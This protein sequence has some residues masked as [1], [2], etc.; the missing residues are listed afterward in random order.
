M[1]S[2]RGMRGKALRGI[3]KRWQS[4]IAPL[5]YIEGGGTIMSISTRISTSFFTALPGALFFALESV[6]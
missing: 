1:A 5:H 6:S 2:R 4:L 3:E